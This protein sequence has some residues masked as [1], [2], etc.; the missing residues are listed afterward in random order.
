MNKSELISAVVVGVIVA[1]ITAF[2]IDPTAKNFHEIS[3]SAQGTGNGPKKAEETIVIEEPRSWIKK[4]YFSKSVDNDIILDNELNNEFGSIAGDFSEVKLKKS[5][6][7]EI[8]VDDKLSG[9]FG[10]LLPDQ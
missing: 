7:K 1:T 5:F 10:R 9:D 8:I 4:D 3:E 2:V 6:E